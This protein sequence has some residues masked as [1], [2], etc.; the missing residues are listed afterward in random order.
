M[1][2]LVDLVPK[3]HRF[4]LG[5]VQSNP[6]HR[7][8]KPIEEQD[9]SGLVGDDQEQVE[10]FG[11]HTKNFDICPSAVTAFNILKKARMTPKSKEILMQLVKLQDSFL[12]I[13]KRAI[14]EKNISENDLKEMIKRLNETHFRVGMLS[15]RF[16]S[17][18]RKHLLY[19]TQ[20]IFRTLPFYEN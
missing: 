4:K 3:K 7:V 16:G 1:D 12:G 14:K 19:T 6:Y 8:F 11:Y 18:L 20:H 15:E 13:E 10:L 9:D 2:K 17:E 5:Q